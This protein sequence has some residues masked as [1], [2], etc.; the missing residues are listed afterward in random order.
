MKVYLISLGCAKNLVDSE[1]VLGILKE[2]GH[3][4]VSTPEEAEVAVVNTCGFIRSGVE[5][6]I[7]V[8]L[9]LSALK[10]KGLTGMLVVMGCVVQRYGYK[11]IRE[12]PEVD[13]WLGTGEYHRIEEVLESKIHPGKVPFLIG[14]PIFLADERIPRVRTTP[15]FTAYL[16]IAEGCSHGCT[17][18]VIPALRGPFRSRLPAS[19]L[20]EAAAMAAEGVRE[21][22][23]VAQDTTLYGEDLGKGV[24]LE[25]LLEGLLGISELRWIRLLYCHPDR[26][27]G[28]LLRL[29]ESEER[30]CPYLD[31]PLQHVS[32][33]VLV[34]MGRGSPGERALDLITRIRSIKR[35]MTIRTTLM[36]GFPGET[37]EDFG[38]LVDFVKTVR[39]NRLGVFVYSAE[40]GTRASRLGPPVPART[41]HRRRKTLMTLQEKIS[42]RLNKTLVGQTLPVLVEGYSA[43]TELL[44]QGRT[45]GMAPDV[46]GQVLINKG[47]GRIGEI[48]PVR[49]TAA[50][51]HDL[52][53]EIV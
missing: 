4:L 3:T 12:L 34:S 28:R 11:L 15:F 44:L 41:A 35:P 18:C 17:F 33:S 7:G 49:I 42:G 25:D 29:M 10:K 39:L 5:E 14:R 38:S 6:A 13:A 53:G 8:I 1:H 30:L 22:N 52:I 19:I 23:L 43:E 32:R 40:P 36:V 27:S 45:Q 51:A 26:I 24:V 46:D 37:E 21:I 20:A 16:K 9:E 50:H 2:R 47:E 48:M 31:I